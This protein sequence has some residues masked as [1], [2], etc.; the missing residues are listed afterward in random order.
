MRFLTIAMPT[1]VLL[2]VAAGSCGYRSES[3]PGGAFDSPLPP[4]GPV[5]TAT[6]NVVV[7]T[8]IPSPPPDKG[9]ITGRFV[10][11]ESRAPA[12]EMVMHLGELSPLRVG[13]FESHLITILPSSSPRATTDQEGY[14]LFSD[15]EPGTHAIVVWTPLNSWVIIDA[16][17]G[18]ELLVTVEAGA[19]AD[20]GEVDINAPTR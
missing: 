13:D 16:E 11:Y 18:Q 14:F 7:P 2:A 19:V 9:A 8:S 17:T 1:V 20:L 4:S 10:D 5:V 6:T 15:V 12:A 3:T